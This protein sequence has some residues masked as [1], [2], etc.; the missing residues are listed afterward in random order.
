[1]YLHTKFAYAGK[2]CVHVCAH[3]RLR[4]YACSHPR[5]HALMHNAYS[6]RRSLLVHMQMATPQKPQPP[7]AICPCSLHSWRLPLG[8]LSACLRE[9]CTFQPPHPH[10]KLW[11]GTSS[12]QPIWPRDRPNLAKRHEPESL[13][14]TLQVMDVKMLSSL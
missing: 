11:A 8:Y 4:V 2:A 6:E 9:L 13:A 12:S 1:M 14:P 10:L 5:T 7:P 3:V